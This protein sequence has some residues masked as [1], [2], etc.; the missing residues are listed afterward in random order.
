MEEAEYLRLFSKNGDLKVQVKF[1]DFSGTICALR[2]NPE[3]ILKL[4]S[5]SDGQFISKMTFDE[6]LFEVYK[7]EID[8]LKKVITIRARPYA[9][10][11][12]S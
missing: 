2:M 3:E 12:I 4:I 1:K 11:A 10:E 8:P 6:W 9:N 5:P 7:Y